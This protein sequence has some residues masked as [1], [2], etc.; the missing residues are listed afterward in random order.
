MVMYAG[1]RTFGTGGYPW[2][3]KRGKP[4]TTPTVL[5]YDLAGIKLVLNSDYFV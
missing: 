2:A 1:I 3:G 5:Q 4:D